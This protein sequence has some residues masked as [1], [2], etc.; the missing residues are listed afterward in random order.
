LVA[1][2]RRPDR[3]LQFQAVRTAIAAEL[4]RLFSNA[5]DEPIPDKV[6]ELIKQLDQPPGGGQ[7]RDNA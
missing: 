7:H 1:M 4:K 2:A 6:A 5:L 3:R